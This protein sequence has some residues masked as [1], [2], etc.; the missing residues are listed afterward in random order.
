MRP[1]WKAAP[2]WVGLLAACAVSDFSV[3]Q[4]SKKPEVV[5]SWEEGCEDARTLLP[6]CDED[7]SECG[8]YSCRQV[9]PREA[10][11]AYRGGGPL[12]IPMGP[13]SPRR[14]WGQPL[15]LPRDTQPVFT[16][17]FNRHLDP[18]PLPPPLPPGRW[19]RHHIF[20]QAENLKRWFHDRGIP[21]IHQFT[22]LIPE[23]IHLRIHSG[24]PSGGLW[25]QAW[26]QFRDAKGDA[27]TAE[28]YR[29]AGELIFRFN[30]A[31]PIVPYYQRKLEPPR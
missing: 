12:Y 13:A 11:L 21:N 25:N 22:M 31:G 2:L 6:L 24:A 20:P 30:L 8:L 28:I 5:T 9:V 23:P 16:F 18:K 17:R 14:W 4:A 3:H 10:L 26:R 19:V 7:G 15:W 27:S 29:H 1:L